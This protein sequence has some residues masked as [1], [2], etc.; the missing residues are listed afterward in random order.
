MVCIKDC[1]AEITFSYKLG[2]PFK[3][4]LYPFWTCDEVCEKAVDVHDIN[5]D[6][7]KIII[8]MVIVRNFLL[9]LEFD[10]ICVKFK[11]NWITIMFFNF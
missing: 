7:R 5:S 1:S 9:Y 6:V 8:I 4:I 2:W 10:L 3:K 11:V